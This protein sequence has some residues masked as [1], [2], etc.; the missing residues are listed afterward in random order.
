[1]IADKGDQH[2]KRVGFYTLFSLYLK[3]SQGA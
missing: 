1:M 3:E 2:Q